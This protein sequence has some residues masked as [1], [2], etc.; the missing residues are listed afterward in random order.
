M[1]RINAGGASRL[2]CPCLQGPGA[3][4]LAARPAALSRRFGPLTAPCGLAP[5]DGVQVYNQFDAKSMPSL[6]QVHAKIT[7]SIH[8]V[9]L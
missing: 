9:A 6:H 3:K 7:P 5:R 2:R 1:H 4:A 8:R